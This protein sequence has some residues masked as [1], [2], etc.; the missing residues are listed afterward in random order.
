M[1]FPAFVGFRRRSF[2]SAWSTIVPNPPP[3]DPYQNGGYAP[4]LAFRNAPNL[5]WFQG[6]G[7]PFWPRQRLST[8]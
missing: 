5:K 2:F 6:P 4:Y 1:V 8:L 3:R 7:K